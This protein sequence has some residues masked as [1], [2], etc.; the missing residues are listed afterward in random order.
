MILDLPPPLWTPPKPA[1]IRAHKQ[2]V[3]PLAGFIFAPGLRHRAAVLTLTFINTA[4]NATDQTTYNFGN[5]TAASA[6]LMIVAT[7]LQGNAAR[8]VSSVSIGGVNGTIHN[9]NASLNRKY[10]L[11]SRVVAAGAQAVSVTLSGNNGTTPNASCAV[12][13]L[14][15]YASATPTATGSDSHG[16]GS[17]INTVAINISAGGK[18]VFGSWNGNTNSI[19]WSSATE[20]LDTNVNTQNHSYADYSAVAAESPHTETADWASDA[21]GAAVGGS[22][23]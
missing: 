21:T 1:I 15:N 7:L 10:A 11:A 6:G 4:V 19:T 17:S 5:F 2:I 20:R 16:S 22:W 13:L 3:D 18:A 14:T 8:T 23:L 12:W 9:S